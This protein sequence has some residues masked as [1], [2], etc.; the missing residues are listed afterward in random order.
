MQQKALVT[1]IEQ[2]RAAGAT[3]G[4]NQYLIFNMSNEVYGV[5]IL[6]VKEIIE[7]S[8]LT[9]VP[10]VPHHIRGVLNLR[11]NVVPVIDLAVRLGEQS[12]SMITK[13]TCIII[14]EVPYGQEKVDMGVIVDGVND[15]VALSSANLESAPSFGSRIRPDFIR[16]IGKVNNQFIILLDVER[17]LSVEELS[18]LE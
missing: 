7:Y 9:L 5:G 1:H 17:V 16:N 13:H 3:E 4:Q 8:A 10:M 18:T 15:V 12:G 6:Y 2:A 14:V 11:G